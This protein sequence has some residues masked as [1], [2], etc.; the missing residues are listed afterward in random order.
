M[1]DYTPMIQQYLRI[2]ANYPDMLL[3]YR[4]GDFYEL[5]FDD[6]KSAAK[7]L[8]ITL[9]ARGRE[10]SHPVPMAGVPYHAAE[11]YI[12]K[13]IKQGLSVAICEQIGDP[14][15]AN[16]Q[17][18][19]RQVTRI[20]TPGTVSDAAFLDEKKSTILLALFFGKKI[21]LAY[22]ELSSGKFF[23]QEVPNK[24]ILISELIRI[25]PSEL[26]IE[27]NVN[28]EFLSA[29]SFYVKRRSPWFFDR[30]AGIRLLIEQM[31]T[32]DLKA[33]GCEHLDD[34]MGAA[35]ALLQYV[36]ET[37]KQA[38]PHL[39]TLIVENNDESLMIDASSRRHLEINMNLSS[40]KE[41]TL[42]SILDKTKSAMGSRLLKNWLNR[43]I[44]D[45]KV[46]QS[47]LNVITNFH[48][49]CA[50]LSLHELINEICDIERILTRIA[51]KSA[52]PR[53][54]TA[55]RKTL[56][57]L[58]EIKSILSNTQCERLTELNNLIDSFQFLSDLLQ[59]AIAEEPSVVIRDGNV[60]AEQFDA[61]LDELRS[62]S[63][64]AS[65]FLIKLEEEERQKTNLSTLKVGYNR[66]HGYYI[67]LS[68]TQAKNAP[69]Y[70]QRRQTLKNAERFITPELKSFEEKAL[71]AKEHALALEK[72]IYEKILTSFI[73]FIKPLQETANAIAEIDVLAT[74]AER[75]ITLNWCCPT[76]S[77]KHCLKI[78][79]GRHPVVEEAIKEPFV[80]NDIALDEEK[81]MLM[82]TGPN[83]GGKSTYMRQTA[84]IVL[85]SHVGS[86]VP[87]ECAEI[88]SFD[89]IFTRIGASD[90][91]A[92]GR[93]T[94]MVEMTETAFI[95]NHLTDKS[96]VLIDEIG[97]GTSTFDG[98]ALAFATAKEF[99]KRNAFTLF[100]T[101]YFELTNLVKEFPSIVNV[102]LDATEEKDQ[103]IFLHRV[104]RGPA[105]KSYGIQV[106][107]LAGMP[108][109]V[110]NEAKRKLKE[111]ERVTPNLP[112]I[113]DGQKQ[114]EPE[115]V[116]L[117][118]KINPDEL[119]PKEA[120]E[121]IYELKQKTQ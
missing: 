101:H 47:R 97:R 56:T 109:Q 14:A 71:T 79:N 84:L 49:N 121:W 38:L 10:S 90:D 106:A 8:D 40:G 89:R 81:R 107:K 22:L 120:L 25:A 51:L 16:G 58:P 19:E 105:N 15:N 96:L 31:Q 93:S 110:I 118:R 29:H 57:L 104:A 43:P 74:F 87:A 66:V 59:R 4:M 41:N 68:Q 115:V 30:E 69:S 7:L 102:H 5:F 61:E 44:L 80:P 99:A 27:E 62:I 75:A 3:F 2:K 1:S 12:G 103:L 18:I 21:G 9:T 95:L 11:N 26:L 55:L 39:N 64:N 45:K 46:L 42:V 36:K 114:D 91:L 92:S 72:I 52:K 65:D 85:L 108:I 77:E 100:A 6:A 13:L 48:Q 73:P 76:F 34:A 63:N 117:L 111:L 60:I 54:L 28:A 86:F 37:Q 17:P 33:Y 20:L 23:L 50:Y 53:D 119:N 32:K 35:A 94:F 24:E 116:K 88:G 83:M 67:E 78:K 82:I 70:Y 98:L 112:E 113:D